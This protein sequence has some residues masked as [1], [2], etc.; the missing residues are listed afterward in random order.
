MMEGMGAL[1]ENAPNHLGGK[2]PSNKE[3]GKIIIQYFRQ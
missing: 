1:L 2:V 3:K